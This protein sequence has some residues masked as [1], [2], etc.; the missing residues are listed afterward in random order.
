MPNF[1]LSSKF[2]SWQSIWNYLKNISIMDCYLPSKTNVIQ[3]TELSEVAT[4][5]FRNIYFF[6]NFNF[7]WFTT[8]A[9]DL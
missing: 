6:D 9:L 7:D 5:L 4:D 1:M 3:W 2:K 8:I